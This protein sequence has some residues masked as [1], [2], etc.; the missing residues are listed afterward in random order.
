[1]T[2]AKIHFAANH[3]TAAGHFPGNPIIPGALLLDE[4]MIALHA[5]TGL[6]PSVIRAAKFLAPVRP[7]D[8]LVLTCQKSGAG[9]V[10]F[11]CRRDATLVVTGTVELRARA[12]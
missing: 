1:M 3:P 2:G 12:A 6:H 11:E 4:V 10:K 5:E 9:A 7:G 8:T